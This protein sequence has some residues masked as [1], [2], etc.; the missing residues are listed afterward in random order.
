M[1]ATSPGDTGRMLERHRRIPLVPDDW[2]VWAC[3]DVHG[4]TSAL[5]EALQ[6]AGILDTDRHW[7]APPRTALVGCGDYLDRGGDVRGLVE[8]LQRLQTEAAARGGAVLL[9]RGNHEAMPLMI[10]AGAADWLEV[11]REYGGDATL[12]SYGCQVT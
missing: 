7:V 11:W 5:V 9:A 6:Q 1:P 8:L 4:V 10:R 2:A 12:A 3:T